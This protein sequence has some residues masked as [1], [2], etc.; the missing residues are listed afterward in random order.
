MSAL[1][2]S[3]AASPV[4][5]A[6][7]A[8]A[9]SSSAFG[10]GTF[11]FPYL[12]SAAKTEST[13]QNLLSMT[14]TFIFFAVV[15]SVLADFFVYAALAPRRVS[16]G[17]DFSARWIKLFLLSLI[18]N[19]IIDLAPI[20]AAKTATQPAVFLSATIFGKLL[21]VIGELLVIWHWK[22][23]PLLEP[24]A[25]QVKLGHD[26][27]FILTSTAAVAFSLMA[28]NRYYLSSDAVED[29]EE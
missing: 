2:A 9:A 15:G 14:S 7:T 29:A 21:R 22:L 12:L 6:F 24:L 27:S 25:A 16:Y 18:P 5:S 8:G 10:C 23:G 11:L 19:P 13:V 17:T 28:V 26:W 20:Y 1:L 3:V 4:A